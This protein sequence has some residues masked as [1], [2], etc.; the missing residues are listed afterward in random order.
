MSLCSAHTALLMTALRPQTAPVHCAA[1]V[2]GG[3][4]PRSACTA[5]SPEPA[6]AAE[7]AA[8]MAWPALAAA[9]A[10]AA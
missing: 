1:S 2:P 6:A 8:A 10:C 7:A 4:S 5:C 9:S 3:A